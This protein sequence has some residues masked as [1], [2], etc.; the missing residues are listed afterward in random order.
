[1][2]HAVQLW[3]SIV[4]IIKMR[5]ISFVEHKQKDTHKCSTEL[6][7]TPKSCVDFLTIDFC[8]PSSSYHTPTEKQIHILLLQ[9]VFESATTYWSVFLE[10]FFFISLYAVTTTTTTTDKL[11]SITP[12]NFR[13]KWFLFILNGWTMYSSNSRVS[14]D[15]VREFREWIDI[16]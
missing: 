15:S 3:R 10:F 1:M 13:E 14:A 2:K 16:D 11:C 9:Y 6:N 8:V 4:G 5:P 12:E 7:Q